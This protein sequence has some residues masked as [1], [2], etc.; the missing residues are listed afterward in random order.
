MASRSGGAGVGVG[1]TVALLG[2]GCLALF[3]LTIVFYSKFQ[4]RQRA[5]TQLE[6]QTADFV[7]ESERQNDAIARIKS[8]AGQERKSVVGYLNDSLRT[9]M[10]KVTGA[11]GDTVE[12]L[13][14]KLGSIEGAASGNLLGVIRAR[15]GEIARLE[16]EL[17]AVDEDRQTALA[18][19]ANESARVAGL[20]ES[21]QKT[22]AALN[23]QIDRYKAEVEA[24][25][26]EVNDTKS[27]MDKAVTEARNQ[28]ATEKSVMGERI[29]ALDN[30]VLILN[31][32]IKTLRQ[33]KGDDILQPANEASL[34]DGMIAT[35]NPAEGQVFINLGRRDKVIL[36]MT[37][38][39]Y[40]DPTAIRPGPTG[41]YPRGKASIEVISVGEDSSTARVI[42][43]TEAR[44]N[45]VVK[46]DVVANA[47]YDPRKVYK[48]VVRAWGG[49]VAD[50][51]AGDVDFLVLGS[52]PVLPPAPRPTD[53]YGIV[54]E[55]MRRDAIVREYE[56]TYQQAIAT[57]MPVLNENRLYTLIGKTPSS[58]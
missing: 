23:D 54:E 47:I 36:G 3:I 41:D 48:F 25:R 2:V 50:E 53:P 37:F 44:G 26:Q 31:D 8:L 21:H 46:G 58:R 39:V 4:E 43:G 1:I 34:V 6:S 16:A 35:V 30:Q 29:A 42:P 18:N 11:P 28:L 32:Q 10:Q 22:L 20:Q 40:S 57:S 14:A 56:A 13:T 15:D 55:Y 5:Y 27:I 7:K 17:A 52:K 45:P 33:E 24:Y 38:A 9:T 51:L 12:Q 49:V 19:L